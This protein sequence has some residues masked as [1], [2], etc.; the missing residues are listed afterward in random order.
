MASRPGN[1]RG[2][3]A[4]TNARPRLIGGREWHQIGRLAKMLGPLFNFFVLYGAFD[5]LSKNSEKAT[6]IFQVIF[7]IGKFAFALAGFGIDAL[8]G[9]LT[10][11]FGN[12]KEGPIR[13]GFRFLF[14]FLSFVGGFG[15]LRYLLNPLKI[16]S[17]GKKLKKIFSDQTGREVE[18]KNYEMWRI[19]NRL[20]MLI[21]TSDEF[22]VTKLIS[23]GDLLARGVST[24]G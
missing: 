21:E 16:F 2:M 18:A 19:N 9:G 3:Y 6:K 24:P 5:W 22:D 7:G 4:T 13:R 12:F 23:S 14:G 17:D 8:F 15:V 10:N 1:V 11:M 20:F